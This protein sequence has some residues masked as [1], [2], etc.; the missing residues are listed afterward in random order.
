M[1]STMMATERKLSMG[2]EQGGGPCA[3]IKAA[4]L[5][6]RRS[7][8]RPPAGIQVP[9]TQNVTSSVTCKDLIL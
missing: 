3:V 7:R 6:H 4:C 8:V 2:H 1:M 9:K 5:E